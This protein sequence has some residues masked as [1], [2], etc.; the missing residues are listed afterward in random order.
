MTMNLDPSTIAGAIVWG[1]VA[2]ALT[3]ALLLLFS[4]VFAKVLIPWYQE[5]VYR[6]VDLR[7]Q[8]IS[9]RTDANGITY[10]Y[11]LNIKQ[12]AHELSGNMAIAKVNSQPNPAAGLSGDYVQPFTV[13]GRV[14]EGFVTLQM[15]STDRR[16]LS[17]AT[18]LLQVSDRGQKLVGHMAYRSTRV[19][20][21]DSEAITWSRT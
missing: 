8:W 9:H 18:S 19:D 5:I 1:V 7:G 16:S 10:H 14:W 21:V 4:Q 11:T 6:G 2:G 20:Q 17:L 13:E 3:S 12:S 15:E